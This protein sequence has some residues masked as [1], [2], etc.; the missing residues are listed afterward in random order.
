MR[1][2]R[3]V[4]S[5]VVG[6]VLCLGT[7]IPEVTNAHDNVSFGFSIGSPYYVAPAPVYVAPP[8]PPPAVVYEGPVY[9]QPYLEFG[10]SPGN[11]HRW[12][13]REWHEHRDHGDWGHHH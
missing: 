4:V 9:P 13:E 5:T 7:A 8:P 1:I 3:N 6:S 11:G 2:S 12:R 10:F